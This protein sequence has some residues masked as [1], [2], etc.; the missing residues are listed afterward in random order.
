MLSNE[1]LCPDRLG[2]MSKKIVSS[3]INL[4]SQTAT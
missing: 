2:S 3:K 1:K 4:A